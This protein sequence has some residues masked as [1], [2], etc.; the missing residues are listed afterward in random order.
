MI[1][2]LSYSFATSSYLSLPHGASSH[3][4]VLRNRQKRE[5]EKERPTDKD[6]KIKKML[7]FLT[8]VLITPL[9]IDICLGDPPEVR[10]LPETVSSMTVKQHFLRL[11]NILKPIDRK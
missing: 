9:D 3:L 1:I 2:D 5:R 10:L 4:P 6:I 7:N 8:R 11:L